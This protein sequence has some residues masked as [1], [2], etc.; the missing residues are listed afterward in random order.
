MHFVNLFQVC[1]VANEHGLYGIH[2]LVFIL[3]TDYMDGVCKCSHLFEY[4]NLSHWVKGS[5]HT[6]G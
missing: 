3:G 1:I 6:F 4:L 2:C 5:L